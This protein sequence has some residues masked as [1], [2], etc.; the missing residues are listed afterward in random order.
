M[1]FYCP[2]KWLQIKE[3]HSNVNWLKGI[4]DADQFFHPSLSSPFPSPLHLLMPAYQKTAALKTPVEAKCCLLL[5]PGSGS[6]VKYL[7]LL[8]RQDAVSKSKHQVLMKQVL[9]WREETVQ[10]RQAV[11]CPGEEQRRC[12]LADWV[13]SPLAAWLWAHGHHSMPQFCFY[14]KHAVTMPS[15]MSHAWQ[16]L[17]ELWL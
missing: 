2:K 15:G 13:L 10:W 6:L 9:D 8:W 14:C 1:C 3:W 17:T 16:G 7:W 11:W 5:S 12:N 4:W